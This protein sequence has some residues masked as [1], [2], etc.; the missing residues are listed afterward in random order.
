MTPSTK[1]DIMMLALGALVGG[2]IIWVYFVWELNKLPAE[3][4]C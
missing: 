3:C 1:A 4:W 2:I